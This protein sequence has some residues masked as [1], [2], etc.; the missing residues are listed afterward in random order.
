LGG[1]IT[2][3]DDGAPR[4]QLGVKRG[5]SGVPLLAQQA[6]ER[7]VRKYALDKFDRSDLHGTE[8]TVLEPEVDGLPGAGDALKNAPGEYDLASCGESKD[9]TNLKSCAHADA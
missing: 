8:K 5:L 6:Y 3:L 2:E 1:G 7:F 4:A 9:F